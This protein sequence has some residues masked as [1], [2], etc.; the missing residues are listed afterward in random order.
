MSARIGGTWNKFRE[1]SGMIVRKQGLS[2][3]QAGKIYVHY[4]RQVLLHSCETLELTIANGAT[5]HSVQCCMIYICYMY[6]SYI[7]IYTICSRHI[8]EQYPFKPIP[9][10]LCS[11]AFTTEL[12]SLTQERSS[13]VN[14]YT[15]SYI[16]E[17]KVVPECWQL[18]R[19]GPHLKKIYTLSTSTLS[20][21]YL[22]L[23]HLPSS[24]AL[25]TFF[26]RVIKNCAQAQ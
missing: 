4:V 18:S 8:L 24:I 10:D 22:D 16:K 11:D 13:T 25:I 21:R 2:L 17:H 5:L 9:L 23:N 6:I 1:L 15:R 14:V 7:I 19:S 3:K 26:L 20:Q 12:A